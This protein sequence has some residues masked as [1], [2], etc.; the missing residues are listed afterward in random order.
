MLHTGGSDPAAVMI[1]VGK[2]LGISLDRASKALQ[3][4]TRVTTLVDTL[5]NK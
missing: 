1:G 4:P 5:Q 2:L 3:G